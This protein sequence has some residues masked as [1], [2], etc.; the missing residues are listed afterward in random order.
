MISA[1]RKS[2]EAS[3][4]VQDVPRRITSPFDCS[5]VAASRPYT[6]GAVGAIGTPVPSTR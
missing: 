2:S 1:F 5:T 3:G 4:S 6:N